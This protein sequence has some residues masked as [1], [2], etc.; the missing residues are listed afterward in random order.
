LSFLFLRRFFF[1]GGDRKDRLRRECRGS[2]TTGRAIRGRKISLFASTRSDARARR[3]FENIF[4][5]KKRKR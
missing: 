1:V 2:D 5:V 4:L 3:S